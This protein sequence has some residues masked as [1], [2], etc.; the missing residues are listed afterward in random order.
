ME[1][2]NLA[3]GAVK[4][5]ACAGL[6][7]F[8]RVTKMDEFRSHNHVLTPGRYVGA[9][10]VEADDVLFADRLAVLRTKLEGDFLVTERLA[11]I[12]RSSFDI[13]CADE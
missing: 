4:T 6:S 2:R 10:D 11:L 1:G 9:A 8:W 13:V 5:G 7:A 3:T 12:I